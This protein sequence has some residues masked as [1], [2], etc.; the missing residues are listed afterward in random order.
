MW[1]E[2]RI[3][4]SYLALASQYKAD[5]RERPPNRLRE[6]R[7]EVSLTQQQLADR[8]HVASK[9]TISD[10]ERGRTQMTLDWMRRLAAALGPRYRAADLLNDDDR[11]DDAPPRVKPID[12]DL[13][14]EL[15]QVA[16]EWEDETGIRLP[17]RTAAVV[18]AE[19]YAE[20]L[21]RDSPP[22][23]DAIGASTAPALRI[24]SKLAS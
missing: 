10:L 21:D 11:A 14:M 15:L 1:V 20:F 7:E 5:M 13:L 8:A 19:K 9:V 18:L 4:C 3:S 6:L 2:D 24:A 22:T 23:A 12:E 17:P 16:R